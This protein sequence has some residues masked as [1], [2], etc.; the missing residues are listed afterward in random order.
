MTVAIT[1]IEIGTIGGDGTGLKA[2]A[3]FNQV[4]VNEAAFK[5]TIE[6]LQ[7]RFWTVQNSTLDPL[8]IGKRYMANNHAGI[9]FTTPA[10]FTL[11]STAVSDIWVTNA[12]DASDITLT[13]ASGDAFFVD[14]VTL[15][16]DTTK[17][18]TPGNLVILS[19]RTT[20]SE[21]DLV[22]VGSGGAGGWADMTE[23]VWAGGTQSEVANG[24]SAVGFEYDTDVTYSTAGAKLASWSNNATEKAYLT[25][26]GQLLVD[27]TATYGD[28]TGIGFG[29]GGTAIYE[30]ADGLL[31]FK[32]GANEAFRLWSSYFNSTTSFGAQLQNVASSSTVPA[33]CF[34]ADTDTGIGR[35][36]AD[37]LSLIAGAVEGARIE[38][39]NNGTVGTHIFIPNLTTAP[40]GNATAGGYMYVEAGALKYRGSSGTVTTLG[41][42]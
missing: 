25:K 7:G 8:V 27:A 17:A 26:D 18:I 36:A 30:S 20:D 39:G 19:P 32:S 21:W 5:A 35:A 13:P 6:E 34:T 29:T 28:A 41:V 4:N 38:E 15:G 42:A 40:T 22:V 2:R 31:R 12:D 11:S 33:H 9:T 23:A 1:P 3:A 14:G 16:A 10:T 24:A 37:Q